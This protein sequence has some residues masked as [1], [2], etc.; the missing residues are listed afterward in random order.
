MKYD[1]WTLSMEPMFVHCIL[2]WS[3]WADCWNY[4][5]KPR[6]FFLF[7]IFFDNFGHFENDTV[8]RLLRCNYNCLIYNKKKFEYKSFTNINYFNVFLF[9][10]ILPVEMLFFFHFLRC[11]F[12][13]RFES[14]LILHYLKFH[15]SHEPSQL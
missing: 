3:F 12:F 8:Q 6:V 10:F 14:K 11:F 2:G 13:F 15:S 9:A 5:L 7:W 1:T 4:L